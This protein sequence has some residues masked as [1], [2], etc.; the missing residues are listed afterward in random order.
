[1]DK[2]IDEMMHELFLGTIIKHGNAVIDIKVDNGVCTS[3]VKGNLAGIVL[4]CTEIILHSC[5]EANKDPK[6]V[7]EKIGELIDRYKKNK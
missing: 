6:D 1:M 3:K 5:E 4:A 7:L 2:T